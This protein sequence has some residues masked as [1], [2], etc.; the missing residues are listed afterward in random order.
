V[1]EITAVGGQATFLKTNVLEY[2]SLVALFQHAIQEYGK[3]DVVV[4]CAG[5]TESPRT[6]GIIKLDENGVPKP[7]SLKTVEVNLLS[8]M[9]SKQALVSPCAN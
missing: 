4:P 1:K 5:I 6:V 8:V 7:P 3:L 2:T 9:N